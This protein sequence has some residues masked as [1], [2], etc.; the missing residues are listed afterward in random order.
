METSWEDVERYH[1][2]FDVCYSELFCVEVAEE[3][4]SCSASDIHAR[5]VTL[6]FTI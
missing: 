1:L 2:L 6:I 4:H 5:V 3:E